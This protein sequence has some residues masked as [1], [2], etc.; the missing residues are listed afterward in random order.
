MFNHLERPSC[1]LINKK[2]EGDKSNESN[3]RIY[4][5]NENIFHSSKDIEKQKTNCQIYF[6]PKHDKEGIVRKNT[7]NNKGNITENITSKNKSTNH[8][9]KQE[10][11]I[12]KV[13]H[14]RNINNSTMRIMVDMWD[15]NK[16]DQNKKTD[17]SSNMLD[18]STME[19]KC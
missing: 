11:Q 13:K 14:E 7:N 19:N 2:L 12:Q 5:H 17:S 4:A 16:L 8:T 15:N 6:T 3:R 1:K 10:V 9:M 18:N